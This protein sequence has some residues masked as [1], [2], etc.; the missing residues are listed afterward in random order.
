[1]TTPYRFV[2]EADDVVFAPEPKESAMSTL[3]VKRRTFE[4]AKLPK[5]SPERAA[6][7]R[8]PL[9]SEYYTGS[10]YL[11]V[12]TTDAGEVAWTNLFRTKAKA[13]KEKAEL[14]RLA[15]R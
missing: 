12:C 7:N 15:A 1:M 13:E 4:A 3:T 14:D 10:P 11:L 6:A 2:G 5:G 8:N 9:T